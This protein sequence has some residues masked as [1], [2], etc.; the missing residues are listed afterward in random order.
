MTPSSKIRQIVGILI[1]SLIFCL[2]FL[3]FDYY[4]CHGKIFGTK[5]IPQGLRS[6]GTTVTAPS[7]ETA[8]DPLAILGEAPTTNPVV[9]LE[10]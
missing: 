6:R 4:G 8:L 9:P 10:P 7:P 5:P 1:W 3:A 2:W